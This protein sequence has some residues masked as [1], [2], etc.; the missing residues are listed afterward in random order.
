MIVGVCLVIVLGF[1]YW[2]FGPKPSAIEQ[3]PTEIIITYWG[4]W[5]EENLIKPL[6]DEYQKQNPNVT[7]N[8]LRQSSLNY[9]TRV[10]TQIRAGTGPDIFRIH[11]TWLGM[12][13]GDLAPAPPEV[14]SLNDYQTA[15]YPVA[16]ESFVQNNQIFAAPIAIDGLALFYNEN[17]LKAVGATPPTTWQ[18]YINAATKMTVKD[19]TGQIKTAGA[20]MGTTGNVDHWPDI[21]GL[22]LLQQPNINFTALTSPGATEVLKFYT[23]FVIDPRRKSWDTNLPSSTEMFASGQLGFYFAPSW[24]AHELRQ[25]NPNLQFKVAPVPQLPGRKVAWATFWGEAVSA[26]SQNQVESWKLIKFLTSKE[27]EKSFYAQAAKIRLFGEPY[28]RTDLAS[29][30]ANDPIVGAFVNQ[31]PYYKYWYTASNTYDVGIN[32]ELNKYFEDAINATLQGQDPQVA[33]QTVE[34]GAKKIFTKYSQ[35]APNVR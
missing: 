8:Y 2:R 32:Q 31:G 6:F 20:A 3:V 9:R 25:R 30:I 12:F 16:S 23:S 22:L 35:S 26:K 14:F 18:E 1:L 29:E 33:L 28:S 13:Q 21:I 34:Q 5:E 27:S 17:L 19:E 11:N 4:L 15:F 24:R 7:V 10:Q